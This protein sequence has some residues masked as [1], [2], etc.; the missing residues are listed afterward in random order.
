MYPKGITTQDR[1]RAMRKASLGQP[2]WALVQQIDE[3]LSCSLWC[4]PG[5]GS[6]SQSCLQNH[7]C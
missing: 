1:K 6:T 3:E 2:V 4:V 5:S 7:C